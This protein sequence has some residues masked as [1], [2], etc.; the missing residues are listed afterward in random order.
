MKIQR[1]KTPLPNNAGRPSI[2]DFDKLKKKDDFFVWKLE[3]GECP[4]KRQSSILT[5]AKNR[6]FQITTRIIGRKIYIWRIFH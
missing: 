5:S 6:G 1:G 3:P 2:Y 4:V